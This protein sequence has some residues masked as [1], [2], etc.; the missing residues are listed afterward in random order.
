MITVHD[1]RLYRFP[2]TYGF[3]RYIY[4]RHS[5]K[6]TIKR[7]DKIIAIS[8]FTKDEIIDICKV[9]P[10][11]IIVIW[12]S[13]NRERFNL[14][15]IEEYK[16]PLEYNSLLNARFLLAVG[17]IEPRKNYERLL[18][19]FKLL[20]KDIRNK[21]L[22]LVIVGKPN[23]KAKNILKKIK[24]ISDVVYLNFISHKLLIWLYKNATLFVFPSFYEGFGF[25]PMEAGNLGTLSVVSNVSSIPEICGECSVYFD[26]FDIKDMAFQISESLYNEDLVLKKKALIES[27]LSRF[28]W[29]KNAEVTLKIYQLMIR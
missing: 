20:K 10:E 2:S 14:K 6:E 23:N 27:N 24:E 8:Q 28:S 18:E 26:P 25:P 15:E 22:K 19:S 17:H 1:L 5:V 29:K 12:E 13:I 11:K 16:L 7:A 3:L 4:L 21:D 9:S